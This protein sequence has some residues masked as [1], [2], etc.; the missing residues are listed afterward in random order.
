VVKTSD[1]GHNVKTKGVR[2]WR[3]R[4]LGKIRG[5]AGLS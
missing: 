4:Q 3:R 5:G 1:F 2:R